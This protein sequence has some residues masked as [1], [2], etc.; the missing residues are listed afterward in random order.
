MTN[1]IYQLSLT[2]LFIAAPVQI[3]P[4]L[5][6][7]SRMDLIDLYE[8][9]M[10]AQTINKLGGQTKL[11]ALSDTLITLQLT[12]Q[13]DMEIRLLPDSTIEVSHEV[14]LPEFTNTKIDKYDL[15]WKRINN[16]SIFKTICHSGLP[17]K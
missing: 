3:L 17:V 2:A 4:L 5:D 15:S 16:K 9:N 12:T 6:K 8:A 14:K 13:S 7:N 11:T 10:N 1:P